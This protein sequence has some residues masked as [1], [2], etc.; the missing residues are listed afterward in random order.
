MF[1]LFSQIKHV[2]L[3]VYEVVT[4][5]GDVNGAGTDANIFIT[6][7]GDYGITPKLHLASK[8]VH[9][10]LC[11]PETPFI[12]ICVNNKWSS[13]RTSRCLQLCMNM[14]FLLMIFNTIVLSFPEFT[15]Q[16]RGIRVCSSLIE[17]NPD[18]AAVVTFTC[19]HDIL[20]PF[21]KEQYLI[22]M[23]TKSDS[24]RFIALH[25]ERLQYACAVHHYDGLVWI[26]WK[27]I[28]L[29]CRENICNALLFCF[30]THIIQ[31]I[32]SA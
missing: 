12:I 4:I 31:T 11:W 26:L 21:I 6:F 24:A 14:F 19:A 15:A 30:Q 2:F 18:L 7:F 25:N 20:E 32:S 27:C 29:C 3:S 17:G 10:K 16:T 5:T 28:A 8:W 13:S 23:M 22:C 9:M 1:S